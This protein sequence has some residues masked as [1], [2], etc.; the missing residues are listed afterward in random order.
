MTPEEK[1]LLERTYKMVEEN[2]DILRKMRRANRFGIAMRIFYWV[3]II[4]ASIGAF[5]FLQPYIN[6]MMGIIDQAQSVVRG[7]NGTVDQAKEVLNASTP[8]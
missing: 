2:N 6:S 4:G 3:V 5:Y 8:R 7:I 1:S